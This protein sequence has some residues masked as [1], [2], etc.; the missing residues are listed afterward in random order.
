MEFLVNLFVKVFIDLF[1]ELI[2]P[3]EKAN[4]HM[5]KRPKLHKKRSATIEKINLNKCLLLIYRALWENYLLC[6]QGTEDFDPR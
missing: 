3:C 6:L 4:I 2:K 5:C 1:T